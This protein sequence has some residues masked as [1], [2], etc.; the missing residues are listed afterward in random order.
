MLGVLAIVHYTVF[1]PS[2]EQHQEKSCKYYSRTRS[3]FLWGSNKRVVG[4]EIECHNLRVCL[5]MHLIAPYSV[6]SGEFSCGI[7]AFY[8]FSLNISY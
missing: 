4:G 6:F 3:Q 2:I 1:L 7:L 5:F 8:L